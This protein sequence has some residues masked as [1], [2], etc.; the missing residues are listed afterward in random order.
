MGSKSNLPQ[1]ASSS[2]SP[3]SSHLQTPCNIPSIPSSN[4]FKILQWNCNGITKKKPF[5]E[6]FLSKTI[7]PPD[8]ICLQETHLKSTQQLKIRGYTTHRIDGPIA[9]NGR[10][11]DGIAT[12]LVNSLQHHTEEL[13][14]NPPIMSSIIQTKSGTKIDILNTYIN[15]KQDAAT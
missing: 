12:L 14:Q 5:L 10:A 7:N 11:T 9:T 15:P 6:A 1:T 2:P 3:P 4:T 8:I 13:T